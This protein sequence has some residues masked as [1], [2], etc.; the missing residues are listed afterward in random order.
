MRAR[1]VPAA[2]V[3]NPPASNPA[4]RATIP[5]P[6]RRPPENHSHHR[7]GLETELA[8][9]SPRTQKIM[10]QK[11]REM[12][13][14]QDADAA[15]PVPAEQARVAGVNPP[16]PHEPGLDAASGLDRRRIAAWYAA[17]AGY[18][19]LLAVFS[20]HADQSWGI[21]AAGGYLLAAI[22]A[23]SY[24][25]SRGRDAALLI[26]AAGALAGPLTWLAIRAPAT[27]DVQVVARAATLLLRHGSPY[28][29][30]GQLSAWQSYDPYLPA[31]TVF[32]LFRAAGLP[33]VT[34][35]PRLWIAL[36][37]VALLTVAFGLAAPHQLRRAD[38]RHQA[39]RRATFAVTTPVLA[40]PLAVGITDP[41]VLALFCVA[42]ACLGAGPA[43]R[44]AAPRAAG[45]RGLVSP[46]RI[47]PSRP[48]GA[49]LAIGIAC[50][51]KLTAWPALPVI[52]V[53]IAARDGRRAAWR[54][55]ATS[56][57]TAGTAIA[58][59]APAALA[60]PSVFLHN[61]VLYP[62]GL[63]RHLTPAAS[64]LPG[65]LLAAT[66]MAGHWAA[67]CLLLAAG[68]AVAAWILLRRPADDR[69]VAWR[70]A[71]GLCVMFILAPA[72]RWG[73]FAYPLGLLGW[74][75]L[76]GPG[77][78]VAGRLPAA[79]RLT[80]LAPA[81]ARLTSAMAGLLAAPGT[82]ET[83]TTPRVPGTDRDGRGDRAL[84][85]GVSP[86]LRWSMT[87]PGEPAAADRA[88][89]GTHS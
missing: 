66:G 23:V 9:D 16:Q 33:G 86:P 50:A 34:G 31:M 60:K 82:N 87:V 53:M 54:F 4:P 78:A 44:G 25:G 35:D 20:R 85:I 89:A 73:Y 88:A 64:A 55:A 15:A 26:G 79:G 83:A 70:L 48:A 62:L 61:T 13:A 46:H 56:A 17:F 28:L 67:I 76:T 5:L 10:S 29:G 75:G 38:R 12:S 21:W 72:T 80:W 77:R 51:M 3:R 45:L 52:A 6:P 7:S 63:T 37:C 18:A 30:P 11:V 81:V 14:Q 84:R 74:L 24:R 41:P 71:A 2:S 40:L 8:V 42:L 59:A 22:T 69:A 1:T 39:L 57:V 58:A 65:H 27:A 36:T 47:R 19:A 43:A 32:G 49:A 68:L